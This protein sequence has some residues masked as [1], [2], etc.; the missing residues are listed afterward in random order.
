MIKPRSNTITITITPW[1]FST[2][3]SSSST[4][5]FSSEEKWNLLFYD[6]NLTCT[7]G[8]DMW[9]IVFTLP[10]FNFFNKAEKCVSTFSFKQVHF[11]KQHTWLQSGKEGSVLNLLIEYSIWFLIF[12]S[13]YAGK[14]ILSVLPMTCMYFEKITK[15]DGRKNVVV[16]KERKALELERKQY[17]KQVYQS[18]FNYESDSITT[19]TCRYN[20]NLFTQPLSNLSVFF[21]SNLSP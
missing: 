10:K 4:G 17:L 15:V 11:A 16:E 19:K 2:V 14:Y 18:H 8:N 12:Q 7:A 20:T 13:L 9:W 5:T 1:Y 6:L 3:K 21:F